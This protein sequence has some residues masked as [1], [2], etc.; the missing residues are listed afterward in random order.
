MIISVWLY[1]NAYTPKF[2]FILSIRAESLLYGLPESE[3]ADYPFTD[4]L[5]KPGKRNE[6]FPVVVTGLI[7]GLFEV[8]GQGVSTGKAWRLGVFSLHAS[9]VAE[10]GLSRTIPILKVLSE[11]F[12]DSMPGDATFD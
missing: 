10:T 8:T 12:D 5:G 3:F 6:G 4:R 1:A 9:G 2:C 7:T 11:V